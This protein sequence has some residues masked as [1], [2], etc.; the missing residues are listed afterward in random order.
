MKL[1]FFQHYSGLLY[2][3]PQVLG[4]WSDCN[5]PK[6]TKASLFQTTKTTLSAGRNMNAYR[7]WGPPRPIDP[8]DAILEK[9]MTSQSAELEEYDDDEDRP[10]SRDDHRK[11]RKRSHSGSKNNRNQHKSRSK[12]RPG[13]RS[14]SPS[15]SPRS[16]SHR[17]SRAH[18]PDRKGSAGSRSK[19]R[20]GSRANSASRPHSR[21][22]NMEDLNGQSSP[23]RPLAISVSPDHSPEA[24]HFPD[25]SQITMENS[26][27]HSPSQNIED[28]HRSESPEGDNSKFSPPNSRGVKKRSP[29]LINYVKPNLLM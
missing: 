12:D 3:D 24:S 28:L 8:L 13:R 18:T 9:T 20:D 16:G 6:K 14:S 23:S 4:T 7:P 10:R 5:T 2:R 27:T 19:S 21:G 22:N 11:G 1:L 17:N 25:T 26:T 15:T 29:L